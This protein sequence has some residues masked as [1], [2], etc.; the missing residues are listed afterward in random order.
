MKLAAAKL[1]GA[2]KQEVLR[3]LLAGLSAPRAQARLDGEVDRLVDRLVEAG[4]A[5]SQ[6]LDCSD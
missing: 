1:F 6:T 2:P 5:T 4:A 3:G